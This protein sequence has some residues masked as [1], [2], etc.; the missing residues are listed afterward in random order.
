M[1]VHSLIKASSPWGVS[2][3]QLQ[4]FGT[5]SYMIFNPRRDGSRVCPNFNFEMNGPKTKT[6]IIL[7]RLCT[8]GLLLNA[9]LKKQLLAQ[10]TA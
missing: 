9:R 1:A 6:Y 4:V 8:P 10:P 3:L 2:Q 7:Q 5:H